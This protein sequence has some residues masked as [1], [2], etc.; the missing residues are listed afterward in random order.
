MGYARSWNDGS[1]IVLVGGT[2]VWDTEETK[3]LVCDMTINSANS[4]R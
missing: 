2:I 1:Y 3:G 4:S